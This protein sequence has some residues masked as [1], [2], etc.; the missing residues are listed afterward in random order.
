MNSRSKKCGLQD[1]TM[2]R[3]LSIAIVLVRVEGFEPPT[4]PSQAEC[5]SRLRYTRTLV[6][7]GR[8]ERPLLRC[9]R[10]VLPLT[11]CAHLEPTDGIEPSTRCLQ[12]S[13]SAI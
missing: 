11:L 7:T 10:S 4:P 3:V 2:F 12:D 5:A 9:K 13:R 1:G 8:V 6:D